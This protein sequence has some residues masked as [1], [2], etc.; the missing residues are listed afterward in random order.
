MADDVI[1]PTPFAGLSRE[2]ATTISVHADE[3]FVYLD[4][5]E[6]TIWDADDWSLAI[7]HQKAFELLIKLTALLNPDSR[8]GKV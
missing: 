3:E 5:D 6:S 7:P 8:G 4:M 2:E 1:Y